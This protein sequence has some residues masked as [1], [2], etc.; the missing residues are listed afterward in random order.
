MGKLIVQQWHGNAAALRARDRRT[1]AFEAYV[2]HRVSGWQPLLTADTA[3]FITEAEQELRSTAASMSGTGSQD[4]V[5]FWAESLGSSRIEGVSPAA[6]R[7][8]HA[9][10]RRQHSPDREFHESVFEVV[11]NIDANNKALSMLANRSELELESLLEAHRVLME[12][13]PTPYLG[14]VVRKDQNWIGGN[15]WHPLEGDFVPPPPEYC[16]DLLEDLVEYVRSDDHSPLLQAA[17][18]HAQ[19]ET[20]HP[21]G[22][23][24]G[25]TG[26]GLLYGVLKQRCAQDAIMPPVS[27]AL[28][29][30]KDR[31]MDSLAQ[32]QRFLGEADDQKR[33]EAIV[34]WLEVLATS[35]HQSCAAARNYQAAVQA[36]QQRWRAAAGGRQRRSILAA[37]INHLP[38]Y[39]SMSASYLSSLTGSSETRCA[40][41]LRK[42]ET[43]GIVKSRRADAKL[44]VYDAD[45]VFDAYEIMASTICD[46]GASVRDYDEIVGQPFV[47]NPRTVER[48]EPE[49]GWQQCPKRVKSTRKPCSLPSRHGGACRHLAHRKHPPR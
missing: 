19:F 38:S 25:R 18:V 8:V 20:I 34:A 10:V 11:G 41:A 30:D 36:L 23:G 2:P 43:L 35:V 42:L 31:Y 15:D 6:R 17:I 4:G 22:D 5:F 9:L 16:A 24:N 12:P 49:A 29:R 1:G 28:S 40:A 33:T 37:A 47:E 13:S 21:F 14:G 46:P 27:L 32:F 44:R 3:A 48:H 45:R 7:V 39:P 26:R